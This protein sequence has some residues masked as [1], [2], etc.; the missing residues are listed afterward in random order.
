MIQNGTFTESEFKSINDDILAQVEE[1]VKF[2]FDSP[3]PRPEDAL[4][5]VYSA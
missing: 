3:Y 5:D 2:A 1:A 4:E